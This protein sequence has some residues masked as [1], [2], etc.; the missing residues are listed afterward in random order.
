MDYLL[1]HK[2]TNVPKLLENRHLQ[3]PG[4]PLRSSR[5]LTPTLHN[6]YHISN[7]LRSPHISTSPLPP[8]PSHTKI[9][10]LYRKIESL[11]EELA[12]PLHTKHANVGMATNPS[13]PTPLL[14]SQHYLLSVFSCQYL[15]APYQLNL[16]C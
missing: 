13:L 9:A 6:N 5:Q 11:E 1:K 8:A 3:C 12:P 16:Y 10:S 15:S 14:K 2:T 7:S 4:I